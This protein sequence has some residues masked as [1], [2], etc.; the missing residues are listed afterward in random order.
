MKTPIF[1][2]RNSEEFL[3]PPQ[4]LRI[5]VHMS[6]FA[7]GTTSLF[8][9]ISHV[10]MGVYFVIPVLE[11]IQF[12]VVFSLWL[13]TVNYNK[14]YV[15]FP[16]QQSAAF[17]GMASVLLIGGENFITNCF[18]I[19]LICPASIITGFKKSALVTY[20]C[21]LLL[22]GVYFV[23][24]MPVDGS[25]EMIYLIDAALFN[26]AL[27]II[28][29][30]IKRSIDKARN[31]INVFQDDLK[32]ETER[33]L[34]ERIVEITH[35]LQDTQRQLILS[36]KM[37]SLGI[38]VSSVA[39][40]INTPIAS[41]KSSSSNILFIL[42]EVVSSL[43]QDYG[44]MNET[45]TKCLIELIT[46]KLANF[47][48]VMTSR[49][50]RRVSEE[51]W[52]KLNAMGIDA[53]S[54][55]T[56][57]LAH[58][59][60]ADKLERYTPLFRH[61]KTK[62]LMKQLL[63]ICDAISNSANIKT[64]VDMVSKI[65]FALK[66]FSHQ[67]DNEDYAYFDAIESIETVLTIYQNKTRN[68]V[69]IFRNY[70][71]NPKIFGIRDEMHQV[72]INLVHNSLQSMEYKGSLAISIAGDD[73]HVQVDIED[74]GRGIDDAIKHRIFE[75]FFTTK[76]TGE[77]SGLGLNIVKKIVE[78]HRGKINFTSTP[79][80]TIFTVV[81]QNPQYPISDGHHD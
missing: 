55:V 49:E 78:K 9:S 54:E 63:S 24:H 71:G 40:E 77:G 44:D 22:I 81:I 57:M 28:T 14:D 39:H 31:D 32:N 66:S 58:L 5:A 19:A 48:K 70:N 4:M 46:A 30:V 80:R 60:V 68:D 13:F 21:A 8:S 72:W 2:R 34:E 37:V 33:S 47:D 26:F 45:I 1:K 18:W 25:Q 10:I 52:D 42:N 51:I 50:E 75:P 56:E 69:K 29:L 38:L 73:K 59:D 43:N 74:T 3:V 16:I 36:E 67:G 7:A 61:K 35:E 65:I 64:S 20:I 15:V 6:L 12:A 11:A 27:G 41:I 79:G 17:V 76:P 62:L 23:L 53:P